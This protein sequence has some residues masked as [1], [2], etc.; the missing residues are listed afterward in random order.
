[1]LELIKVQGETRIKNEYDKRMIR[2]LK[3]ENV[4]SLGFASGLS[5][6]RNNQAE[7]NSSNDLLLLAGPEP[8]KGSSMVNQISDDDEDEDDDEKRGGK[9]NDNE[10]IMRN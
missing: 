1:M 4:P 6:V 7:S 2:K 8:I 9:G 5:S 10:V 3:V